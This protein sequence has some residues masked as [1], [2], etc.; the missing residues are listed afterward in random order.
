MLAVL[1][2]LFVR[3]LDGPFLV[4][5]EAAEDK[6]PSDDAFKKDAWVADTGDPDF[7]LMG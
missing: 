5:T 6:K 1:R 7:P 2:G 3:L 4:N